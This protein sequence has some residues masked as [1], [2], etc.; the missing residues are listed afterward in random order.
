MP[1]SSA[2]L[3]YCTCSRQ[4]YQQRRKIPYSLTLGKLKSTNKR[5]LETVGG[6]CV[7]TQQPIGGSPDIL[8]VFIDN[9]LPVN[10]LGALL[11]TFF[12]TPILIKILTGRANLLFK[13]PPLLY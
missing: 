3:V 11:K 12:F 1:H 8:A 4:T 6:I 10:H 9:Y 13:K 7:I 2:K 5:F